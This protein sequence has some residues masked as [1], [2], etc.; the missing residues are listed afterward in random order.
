MEPKDIQNDEDDSK[1]IEEG[2]QDLDWNKSLENS[3]NSAV[4]ENSDIDGSV[5][6]ANTNDIN[7]H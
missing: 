7:I 1:M 3:Q 6:Y 5:L 2:K 4:S